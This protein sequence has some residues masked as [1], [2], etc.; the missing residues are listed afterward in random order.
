M[1]SPLL[2]AKYILGNGIKKKTVRKAMGYKSGLMAANT[3]VFGK[4]IWQTGTAV[5]FWPM[6]MF[7]KATGSMTRPMALVTTIMQRV[8]LIK[9][10]G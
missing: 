1:D 9:D 5:L 2:M 10:N 3:K 8:Q 4:K 7:S 6:G